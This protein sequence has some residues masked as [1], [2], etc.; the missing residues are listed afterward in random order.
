MGDR[1]RLAV[2]V[3]G[4]AASLLLYAA[5]ILT[6]ARV[7]RKRSIEEFSCVPYIVTLG[8]CLLYTWYGLPVVS[9]RWE[10]LPLV[11]INGLGIFFEISFILVYFRFAETRG[12]IKVAITIIPVILYFAATAAISSFAFH[13][14]HHRKLFTGS[15]GLLAS[16]GM[17]G[18]PLVVMKQVI[19]T[20]SVEFMPFYLSFFSFLASSLWL[21]Y[22]LL[23]HDL[24]IASPNFLGVPFGIIQLVLYFIYR[25]WGV[26]EEPKDRDLERD[27]GEKS[28]QLKL[29]VDEN[30]NGGKC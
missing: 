12:K 23:S 9:C 10:N 18:S 19:T 22:G 24:F 8:N 29:A 17:Y 16:V 11:T 27:N 13:D 30:T 5:P 7:I 28:K 1:L 26:M 15:V 3:M 25:K 20:K 6:F 4:N 14:H 2:G 21:T